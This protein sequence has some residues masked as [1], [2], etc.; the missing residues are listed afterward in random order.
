MSAIPVVADRFEPVL[1]SWLRDAFPD[2]E[3][4][5]RFP[6]TQR[7]CVLVFIDYLAMRT[8]ITQDAN[9]R[10][11]VYK[12]DSKLGVFDL[13]GAHELM[14]RVQRF[15]LAH[16]TRSPLVSAEVLTGSSRIRDEDIKAECLYAVMSVSLLA[17]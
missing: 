10:L 2:V 13:Q 12:T 9:I 8:P 11:T 6:D 15:I 4:A 14:S 1:L 17:G 7:D 16:S 3:F 5:T